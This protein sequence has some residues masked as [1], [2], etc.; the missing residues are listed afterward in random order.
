MVQ[1]ST[2]PFTFLLGPAAA[3][4]PHTSGSQQV[5]LVVWNDLGSFQLLPK[6]NWSWRSQDPLVGEPEGSLTITLPKIESTHVTSQS[7]LSKS[8]FTHEI[9][10]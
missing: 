4:G 1:E 7:L 10:C 6:A 3:S 8:N 9:L 5:I 2:D